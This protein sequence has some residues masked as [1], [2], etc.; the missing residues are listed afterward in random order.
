MKKRIFSVVLCLALML[1]LLPTAALAAKSNLPFTDVESS[2]W[3][4]DAVQYVYENSMMS[5][6][7]DSTFSPNTTTTRGMIV[8][9]LHRLEGC[10]NA[11]GTSFTDVD[12]GAYYATAVAW[13]S[14]RGIVDG[15]GNG[16]FGPNDT[17][18]REQMATILYR[19][20]VYSGY[21]V[22]AKGDLSQ[23][24]DQASVSS[25]AA[26]AMAWAVDVGLISGVGNNTLA[27]R[28]GATRAQ[29][30]AI[31]MRFCENVA[32]DLPLFIAMTY[33]VTFD[34]NYDNAGTYKTVTVRGS[35]SV[36]VPAAPSRIGYT[37]EGWYTD[38]A[39]TNPFDFNSAIF[40]NITLYAKWEPIE[41]TNPSDTTDTTDTDNDRVPDWVEQEFGCDTSLSDTDG[42]QL[43]DY[44]EIFILNSDPAKAD[45]DGDGIPDAE[46]DADGD[47]LTN[48]QEIQ[49]GTNPMSPDTDGDELS[50]AAE[51]NTHKTNPLKADT[52][53][54]GASDGIEISLGTDPL[55]ADEQF[56]I[57]R[58]S[59]AEGDD[60]SATVAITLAGEQIES[61][62]IEP[63]VNDPLLPEDMPGYLGCAYDFSVDG[64]FDTATISFRFDS[65]KLSED[66]DPA[67]FYFNEEEQTLEEL[68]TTVA[69]GV[70]SAVT[71]HFSTYILIDRTIYYDSF[72]W[73]DVWS[74]TG[75]FHSVEIVLVIDDSGSMTSNDSSNQRLTVAQNLI[76]KLPE[77]SKIGIVRFTSST[78]ILTSEL[79]TDKAAAKNY[80]TT[81]YFKSSGGTYMYSA[82]NTAFDL[83]QSE[84]E[85]VLKMMVVL[86]DGVTSDTSKHT[87]TIAAAQTKNVRIYTVGLGS[88]TSYFTTY[89]QPLAEETNA[90]FYLAADAN[91][92][93]AIYE[94]INKEIDLEADS[95]G[96]TIPDYYED[97]MISF[98]GKTITLDKNKADTDGD[99]RMDNEEV[100]VTLKYNE[101]K[102][103]VYVHGRLLSI[104]SM[105]DS[106][107]DGI[108][109]KEDTAPLQPGL[110]DGIVGTLTLVSCYNS[111]TAGWTSGHVFFVY[112]SYIND[113]VN[114]ST[115]AAG[116]S[117]I[118]PSDSWSWNNLQI[119]NPLQASYAFSVGESAT[120]GNG[121]FDSGWFGIGDGSGSTG[122][123]SDSGGSSGDSTASGT[124]DENGVCYNMEVYKHL[125]PNIGYSYIANTYISEDITK[126][127]L[128][129]LIA[130]CSKS[131]VNYWNLT[132]NCA[133]VACQ[134]WNLISDTDVNPY[135]SD[136]LWGTVAT[137]KG[138]K[139]NLRTISGSS[140]NYSL[141]DALQ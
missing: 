89:L 31:L 60:V 57:T 113:T 132:H 7:G 135:N 84:E 55:I 120:I 119:D 124:G 1:S 116:W 122:G 94:T 18:T 35:Q 11:A 79:L 5:G 45:T 49:L 8:T 27:P 62:A 59:Q 78:N 26:E 40:R 81:S 141:A 39:G 125:H 121:A 90:S 80:L 91:Q 29:V 98:N 3:Y 24:A 64:E 100:E 93:S 36:S 48:L 50:D 103:K 51:L 126:A 130:Y 32:A 99:G 85:D 69:D 92:L 15:Y 108:P 41:Q 137:P 37:F 127:D 104:P 14:S 87:S 95:D 131:S 56:T 112:T 68:E 2:D 86:S 25:Y 20:A 58:T 23:F 4:Y 47:G 138:L 88:S 110:K 114:F 44:T 43:D 38:P 53:G 10:P 19:Y 65:T 83:F 123:S 12:S 133:E 71:T 96:D 97:H 111:E 102:T 33:K 129:K 54:D 134:A 76:D 82:I 61:L 22:S 128:K 72:S 73:E 66:A 17:I 136:F 9:V 6:T 109:D 74:S 30:A 42:D 117:R 21:D 107:N 63:R 115:L 105:V 67:I 28:N 140:E 75:T 16:K 13:A 77:D 34:Y 46:K 52:D 101:D 118:N 70:A 139:I 106:D